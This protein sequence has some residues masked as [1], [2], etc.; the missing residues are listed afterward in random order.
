MLV[1][2]E[3]LA[4]LHERIDAEPQTRQL[5][6]AMDRLPESQRAVLELVALEGLSAGEAAQALGISKVAARVRL[7]RARRFVQNRLFSSARDLT[8]RAAE[9]SS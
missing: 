3:D 1:D 8:E 2:A 5:Y 4:R 6:L 9:A 7:H